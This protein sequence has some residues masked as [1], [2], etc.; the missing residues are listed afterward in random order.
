MH[1]NPNTS[2]NSS[3]TL[4][5]TCNTILEKKTRCPIRLVSTRKGKFPGIFHPSHVSEVMWLGDVQTCGFSEGQG[6]IILS[7]G[8]FVEGKL[9]LSWMH[10]LQ[11]RSC[12]Y[13]FLAL[14]F[15]FLFLLLFLFIQGLTRVHCLGMVTRD[16]SVTHKYFHRDEKVGS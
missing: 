7:V 2:V 16:E 11:A 1:K 10:F 6:C 8:A 15:Y 9:Y 5:K 12:L 3:K 4:Q 14:F 13:Y